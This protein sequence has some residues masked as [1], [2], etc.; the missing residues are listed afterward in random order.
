MQVDRVV[1]YI[2]SCRNFDGGYG[3]RPHCESH[4]GAIYCALA[5]LKML[6]R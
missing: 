6:K 5:A 4:S 1:D 2:H 3:L